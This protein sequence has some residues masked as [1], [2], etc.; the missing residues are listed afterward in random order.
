MKRHP[1][2]HGLSSQHHHGLVLA[3]EVTGRVD[4]GTADAAFARE[5]SARFDREV[6]PHFAVEE[7]VLVAALR[8]ARELALVGRTEADHAF[9]RAQ[10]AAARDGRPEGLGAFAERLVDHIRFEERELFPRCE[11]ILPAAVL[12]E[13]DRRTATPSPGRR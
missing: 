2:L 12:E 9:L 13:A 8:A 5:V 6:E 7:E 3:R 1:R 11:E 10:V 4:A